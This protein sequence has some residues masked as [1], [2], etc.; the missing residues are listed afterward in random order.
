MREPGRLRRGRVLALLL[1][2]A[3]SGPLPRA[4]SE[5]PLETGL[6]ERAG[7]RLIQLDVSFIPK[8]K[9]DA[10]ALP[11]LLPEDFDLVINAGQI[12]IAF[13]DRIC[14]MT[15]P[16]GEVQAPGPTAR[17]ATPPPTT[18]P[19]TFVFYVEHALLTMSGQG[20]TFEMVEQ[21]VADLIR[22]GNRGMVVSSGKKVVQSP[23]SSDP[24][25]LLAT[26][27]E[28]WK[29]VS[30]WGEYQYAERE[31]NRYDEM[32]GQPSQGLVEQMARTFRFEEM[33]LTTNRLRRLSAF[34]GGLGQID[35]PKAVLYFADIA[36]KT[37]GSHFVEV[38][39]VS[40]GTVDPTENQDAGAGPLGHTFAFDDVLNEANAQGVRLYTIQAQ[41]LK[42]PSLSLGSARN[43][44]VAQA[45]FKEAEDTMT[46][47]GAETGG[48]M[49]FGGTDSST[50]G[51]I[52]R[53]I[54]QDLGC[55]YL[56]SF[57]AGSLPEDKPLRV[58]LRLAETPGG[59]AAAQR[60]NVRT[61]GQL[62]IQSAGRRE[63]SRVLA[64]H[65]ST[66][67]VDADPGRGVVIPLG[68]GDGSYQAL[69]Q[70]VVRGADWPD[71]VVQSCLWDLGMT[72]V[73]DTEVKDQVSAR[74]T[75]SNPA[76]PVILEKLWTFRP[77][78]SEI[79]SVGHEHQVGQ[80]AT[81]KLELEWPDPDK[82]TASIS[83]IEIV[84]E[85]EGA[86]VRK[87]DDHP[88][89]TR[90]RGTLGVGGGLVRVDQPTYIVAL[91]CRGP[92]VKDEL[93]A[94]RRLSGGSAADFGVL[95]W[96]FEGERCIQLRDLV[97]AGQMGWGDFEYA[98]EVYDNPELSGT[99][100]TERRRSF[101]AVAPADAET[102]A[103]ASSAPGS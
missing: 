94:R 76:A 58:L 71:G 19:E 49:F 102:E 57:H 77:G 38:A 82:G 83:P 100:L 64:A 8:K 97:K 1:A 65:L 39:G 81:A 4:Q 95:D 99:P 70:F 91:V 21:L 96:R 84:Q 62:V 43:P 9:G 36:R 74:V 103:A 15:P 34:L 89:V 87:E 16:E 69:A 22:E 73:H 33:R 63:Q 18:R 31:T 10:T 35:P 90:P 67:A 32:L 78:A 40:H 61:R 98:I 30:Q 54:E 52:K 47:L 44:M 60:F 28:A 17:P 24:E 59:Q 11:T 48:D 46:A 55:F 26:L 101:T 25:E 14:R 66:G 45:R 37:P 12:P 68:F 88:D 3:V 6:V 93:W 27:R 72:Y 86:F 23:L 41:G 29:S 42:P 53:A 85:A 20:T 92:K 80:L 5:P 50:L 75:V 2:A 56:V 51:R 79:V 7:E 13:A